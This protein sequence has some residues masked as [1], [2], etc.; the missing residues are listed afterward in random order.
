MRSRNLPGR[1]KGLLA[2]RKAD[3]LTAISEPSVSLDI[4]QLYGPPRPAIQRQL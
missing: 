1:V 4:S 2:E 3:N